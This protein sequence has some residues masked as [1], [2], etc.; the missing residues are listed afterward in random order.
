MNNL[1][2]SLHISSV[3]A[4]FTIVAKYCWKTRIARCWNIRPLASRLL[5]CYCCE[6]LS[7]PALNT[8]FF[9]TGVLLLMWRLL[10]TRGPFFCFSW[11]GN[12]T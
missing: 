8:R 6:M 2:R 7:P 11:D 12:F 5:L 1:A 10:Y 9:L 4:C 3:C